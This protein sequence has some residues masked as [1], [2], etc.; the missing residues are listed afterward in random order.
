MV[1]LDDHVPG[2]PSFYDVEDR[3]TDQR[4]EEQVDDNGSQ[5]GEQL[6]FTATST[7][8]HAIVVINENARSAEYSLI[9]ESSGDGQ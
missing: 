7:G 9:V 1:S 2:S 4:G 3:V 6:S 8:Y 5:G